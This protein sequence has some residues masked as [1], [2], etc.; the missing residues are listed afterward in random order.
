VKNHQGVKQVMGIIFLLTNIL[1]Y[2]ILVQQ[3]S[4]DYQRP[5]NIE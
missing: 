2:P 1:K 3:V 5:A 4:K